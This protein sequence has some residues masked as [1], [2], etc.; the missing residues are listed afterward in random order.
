MAVRKTSVDK[1]VLGAEEG[2]PKIV[3]VSQNGNGQFKSITEAINSIPHGNTKRIIV[4]IAGGTYNE[5]VMI[6]RTK[7]F[8]TL[9]GEPGNKPNLTY[10]G[11]A[12]R[13]GTVDSTAL[14]Y[15]TVDS[16]SLIVESDYFVAANLII[17]NSAPMPD[18]KRKGAQAVAMRISGDKA[19]FYGCT[20]LGFQDTICDDRGYHFFKDCTIQGTVDFIFGSGKSLYLMQNTRLNVVESIIGGGMIAAHAG[21]SV[22]EDTGYSFVQCE[23]IGNAKGA[24][25]GRAWMTSPKVVYAYTTM[26][27]VVDPLGWSHNNHPERANTVYFGEYKNKGVGSDAKGRAH[28]TKQ[29][30]DSEARPFISLAYIQ[31]SKWL[32]PPPKV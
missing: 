29:L 20:F 22:T 6:N 1:E 10:N 9:F 21:K 19:A 14:Q 8:V 7:P 16:A 3:R 5:K 27:T 2:P 15:G 26:G 17:S 30:S 23:V 4:Y 32:L 11:N 13:F 31:A 18:G 28:F 25:L 12:K 24:F